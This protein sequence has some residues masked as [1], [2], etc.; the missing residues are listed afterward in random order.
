ME[1]VGRGFL[2]R[3]L[4]PLTGSHSTA[5]VFAAGVSSAHS[6]SQ[7]D[8]AREATLLYQI[9]DRCRARGRKLVY[10]STCGGGLYGPDGPSHEAGPVFPTTPYGRHKL[11]MEGV[12]RSSGVETLVLRLAYTVGRDQRGHQLIPALLRQIRFGTVRIHRGA[13]RDLVHV[14]DVV[15]IVDALLARDTADE[16]INIASGFAVPVEDIVAHLETRLG[17]TAERRYVDVADKHAVSNHKLLSL[18]P[19]AA[20]PSFHSDYY[21]S[22]IDRYLDQP[23]ETAPTRGRT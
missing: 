14:D 13:R 18:L 6:T 7:T 9:L 20:R 1:I 8:F 22:V 23:A 21:R 10:F 5:V 4:A 3:S 2:A 19:P 12:L 15:R 17:V 16:V 11:A